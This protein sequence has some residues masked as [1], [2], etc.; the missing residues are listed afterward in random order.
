MVQ[1]P[2]IMFITPGAYPTHSSR[3]SSVEQSVTEIVNVLKD[4]VDVWVVGQ[5]FPSQ[6]KHE[7]VDGVR[8]VRTRYTLSRNRY[9][10]AIAHI[11]RRV[12]PH[13]I[14]IEN[15]PRIV[16]QLKGKFPHI[17]IWLSLHSTTFL[18]PAHIDV[19]RLR[20][21]LRLADQVLVNSRFLRTDVVQRFRPAAAKI[22]VNH[23]GVNLSQ[24]VSKFSV[25]GTQLRQEWLNKLGLEHRRII[26]YVGRLIP[27]KGIHHLLDAMPR[28]IAQHPDA[29][30]IIVGGKDYGQNKKST[31][32]RMLH[33]QG[34]RFTDHVR[35]I[36]YVPHDHI[37][38]WFRIADVVTVPSAAKEAF[39]LVNVEAM[40]TGVP[41]IATKSGGMT[42]LI[43]DAETGF[44]IPVHP[45]PKLLAERIHHIL[46]DP[47]RAQAMGEACIQR[48]HR[49]F[50]WQHTA[51]RLYSWYPPK[52]KHQACRI[53]HA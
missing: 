4:R 22:K 30:L 6:E 49:Y 9:A 14:Q 34:Q 37:Q 48:V 26:L 20:R 10:A 39:G 31:Y 50:T 2:R 38:H 43:V 25:E 42:E 8:Y 41:V 33:K 52:I 23:L 32:V 44:L 27:R 35:F 11:I 29:L 1:K 16:E 28:V 47:K 3:S 7:I 21:A 45:S 53:F 13:L 46:A 51:E 36:P 19:T 17:P 12:R 24:F 5:R 40:A 18:S 15:R